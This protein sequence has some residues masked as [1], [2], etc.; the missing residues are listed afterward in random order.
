MIHEESIF[1][2]ENDIIRQSKDIIEKNRNNPLIDKYIGLTESYERIFK[3]FRLTLK[4][5]DRQ[6]NELKKARD[7][8][9]KANK[10]LEEVNYQLNK[11]QNI[12]IKLIG[13]ISKIRFSGDRHAIRNFAQK[14]FEYEKNLI[15][16][17]IAQQIYLL[18]KIME[19][20]DK[21][22]SY[23]LDICNIF[24]IDREIIKDKTLIENKLHQVVIESSYTAASMNNDIQEGLD[25][26]DDFLGMIF[27][28]DIYL[29]EAYPKVIDIKKAYLDSS[30]PPLLAQIDIFALFY[31]LKDLKDIITEINRRFSSYGKISFLE[32]ITISKAIDSAKEQAIQDKKHE[33]IVETSLK[34]DPEMITNENALIYMIRDLFYNSI[35]A[36]SSAVRVLSKRPSQEEYLPYLN[37]FSFDIYPSLYLSVQ[38]N[39]KGL[40]KEKLNQINDYLKRNIDS[41]ENLSTKGDKKKGGLG[42]KNLRDFL[43]L[44]AGHC[45]YESDQYGTKV[46]LYLEKLEI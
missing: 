2:D 34:Y 29:D 13:D 21:E 7:S 16:Q 46:H 30:S 32:N 24:G 3:K 8:L 44:H 25:V 39:G 18:Y 40:S 26:G 35:D 20:N 28:E 9:R 36:G 41:T 14:I 5:S 23:L 11:R 33:F 17:I 31:V 38:D 6:Q 15:T 42:S 10:N 43:L 22:I 45:C 4:M 12:I 27:S 1:N 19:S 37:N